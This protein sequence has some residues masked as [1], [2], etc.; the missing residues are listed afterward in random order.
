VLAP[1]EHDDPRAWGDALCGALDPLV[2]D[3]MA[4]LLRVTPT[5]PFTHTGLPLDD[6][7]AYVR[8]HARLDVASVR[9]AA[10][11]LEDA[12]CLTT[13]AALGAVG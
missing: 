1:S 6:Q 12:F 11:R 5:G 13:F 10:Q 9:Q 2:P 8:H 4:S 7:V 3:G